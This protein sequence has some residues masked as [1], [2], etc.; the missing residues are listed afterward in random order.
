MI[1]CCGNPDRGDDS[2]GPRVA[3]LLSV[4]SVPVQAV[5]GHAATLLDAWTRLR[6]VIIVDAVVTGAAP[7][8]IHRWDQVPDMAASPSS[9]HGLG[10]REAIQLG[11][12]LG[13]LPEALIVIGVEAAQFEHGAP[14]SPLV[15]EALPRVVEIIL[16]ESAWLSLRESGSTSAAPSKGLDSGPSSTT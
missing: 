5:D 8:T 10:V 12:I 15:A 6:W 9:T 4:H 13:N 16:R 3:E 1:L 7:G 14:L 2:L 11:R